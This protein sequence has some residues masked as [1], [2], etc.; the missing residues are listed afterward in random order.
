MSRCTIVILMCVASLGCHSKSRKY[1]FSPDR[2]LEE[3]V[4]DCR[5]CDRQ[6]DIRAQEE[7]ILRYRDSVEQGQSWRM[8]TES[9]EQVDRDLDKENAFNG[10]MTSKG[11]RQ[12]RDFPLGSEI[13]KRDCFGGDAP[14]HLAGR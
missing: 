3:V 13:R 5:Q 10:C 14:Q 8:G 12:V 4:A 7:H 6:A 1:W 2:T 11:Y 9:I